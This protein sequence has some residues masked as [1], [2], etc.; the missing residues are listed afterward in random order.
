MKKTLLMLAVFTI[1]LLVRVAA[2]AQ[3]PAKHR[4]VVITDK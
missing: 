1:M 3:S 4:L 2:T